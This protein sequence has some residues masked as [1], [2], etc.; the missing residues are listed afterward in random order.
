MIRQQG[1]G[2]NVEESAEQNFVD[3]YAN[4]S[5]C[6]CTEEHRL[7]VALSEQ[8]GTPM[9]FTPEHKGISRAYCSVHGRRC[10]V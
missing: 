5:E 1:Q 3:A 7:H 9:L 6:A 4:L 2:V 8:R 10:K